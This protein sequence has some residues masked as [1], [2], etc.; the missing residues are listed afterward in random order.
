MRGLSE[1]AS[2][3]RVID[4]SARER[5]DRERLPGRREKS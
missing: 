4:E 5:D 3:V 2:E 1:R